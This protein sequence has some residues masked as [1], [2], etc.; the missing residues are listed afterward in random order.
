MYPYKIAETYDAMMQKAMPYATLAPYLVAQIRQYHPTAQT[1]LEVACG[2][3]N[4]LLPLAETGMTVQG[5][6]R[7]PEML[8]IAQ[9]KLAAASLAVPL[10]C[11]DMREPYPLE[12]VDAVICFFGGLGFLNS[13][14]GLRAGLTAIY[15]ALKP[16]G[17]FVCEQFGEAKMRN[18]FKGF[19]AGDWGDFV[20]IFYGESNPEGQV[21][22]SLTFFIKEA[23][24]RYR[25]E[26]ER[27]EIRIHPL[28]EVAETLRQV[29]FELR[30]QH[31]L[32]TV[33]DKPELADVYLFVAQKPA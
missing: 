14:E 13:A 3:G 31:E 33:I 10:T 26:E 9:T 11:Q 20:T 23:D 19:R 30:D 12:P 21:R 18:I 27:H 24:G 17:V 2:T 6:D 15:Q 16:G 1:V 7:S 25:R 28:A 8:A 32:Y 4:L 22:Q 29:G 5:L